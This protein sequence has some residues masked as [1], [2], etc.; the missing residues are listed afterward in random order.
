[1]SELAPRHKSR[2]EELRGASQS[3]WATAFRRTRDGC[4]TWEVRGDR[5]AGCLR[6]TKGGSSKQAVVEGGNGEL[7]VRWMTSLE[8]ARLQGADTF[9]LTVVTANQAMS[10]LGDAVCVPV[11]RYLTEHYISPLLTG[12][13]GFKKS[14]SRT[15]PPE[16]NQSTDVQ[17]PVAIG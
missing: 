17:E 16:M 2:L 8:Y 15:D 11:V 13:I 1:M 14:T 4:V 12:L 5:I 9:P 10:A 7:R 6:T 3:E